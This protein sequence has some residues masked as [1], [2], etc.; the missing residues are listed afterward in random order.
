MT[1]FPENVAL[2]LYA[3]LVAGIVGLLAAQAARGGI[4]RRIRASWRDLRLELRVALLAG[5]IGGAAIANDADYHTTSASMV[6]NIWDKADMKNRLL[7]PNITPASN[8]SR[9]YLNPTID[10]SEPSFTGQLP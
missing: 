5:L 9:Y 1:L 3:V 8:W 10:F 4:A 6:S 7:W 2:A